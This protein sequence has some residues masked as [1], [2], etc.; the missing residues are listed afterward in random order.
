MTMDGVAL[1]FVFHYYRDRM[2][3]WG[4]A[5]NCL[6]WEGVRDGVYGAAAAAR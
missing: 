1:F 4:V 6:I 2:I 3:H 5:N